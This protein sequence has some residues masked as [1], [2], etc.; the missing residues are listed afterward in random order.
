MILPSCTRITPTPAG[1]ASTGTSVCLAGL[2]YAMTCVLVNASLRLSNASCFCCVHSH[3]T[4]FLVSP[5]FRSVRVLSLSLSLSLSLHLSL[6]LPPSLPSLSSVKAHFTV[7]GGVECIT[8]NALAISVVV[9][10]F[11]C[12]FSSVK[13]HSCPY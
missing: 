6:L 4:S 2:K 9:V 13:T 3:G 1:L 11:C 8:F 7:T 12:V 5:R 10:V